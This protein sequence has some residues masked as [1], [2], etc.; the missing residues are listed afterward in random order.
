MQYYRNQDEGI[1]NPIDYY[2]PTFEEF[3][4]QVKETLKKEKH[5]RELLYPRLQYK[6]D[7]L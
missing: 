5:R 1:D 3:K 2:S 7:L 6:D 4:E